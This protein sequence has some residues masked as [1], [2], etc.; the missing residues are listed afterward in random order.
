MQLL[1][2]NH[3]SG[4]RSGNLIWQLKTMPTRDGFPCILPPTLLWTWLFLGL[5][6]SRNGVGA[7]AL[8][9]DFKPQDV[10]DVCPQ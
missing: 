8:H 2:G 6:L 1:H 9:R 7:C 4:G 10:E 5:G 3:C